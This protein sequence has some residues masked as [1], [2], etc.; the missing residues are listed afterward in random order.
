MVETVPHLDSGS[1]LPNGGAVRPW[2]WMW[3]H[4]EIFQLQT[5]GN[6]A[7]RFSSGFEGSCGEHA[8]K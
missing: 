1:L 5:I 7:P 4:S 3:R 8:V 6:T 2:L